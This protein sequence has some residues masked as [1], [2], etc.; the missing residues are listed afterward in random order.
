MAYG[1]S[2]ARGR[3]AAVAANL[4]HSHSNAGSEPYLQPTPQLI[5]IS[6]ELQW[7]LHI[8]FLILFHHDLSQET[9]Y[10]SLYSR[11]SLLIHS[12]CNSLHLLTPNSPS[13]PLPFPSPFPLAT[14][15]LFSSVSLF[16][17]CREVR[18]CHI[19]DSTYK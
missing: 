6:T 5:F 1:D 7:E 19:L 10:S 2:Q 18:L 15:S 17:F 3:I 9:G 12:K 8:P 11:I 16:L 4:H 14:T 13:I